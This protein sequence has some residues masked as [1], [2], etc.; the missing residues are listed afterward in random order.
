MGS[1]EPELQGGTEGEHK[2][3]THTNTQKKRERREVTLGKP[4]RQLPDER[5]HREVANPTRTKPEEHDLTAGGTDQN[6]EH[7]RRN[8]ESRSTESKNRGTV[9]M[10]ESNGSAGPRPHN[11]KGHLSLSTFL[12]YNDMTMFCVN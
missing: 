3:K 2:Q 8:R 4:Q 1:R 5:S 6:R 12:I 9:P 11:V 10:T 7:R